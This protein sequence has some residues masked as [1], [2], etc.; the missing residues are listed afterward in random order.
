MPTAH[1]DCR[2]VKISDIPCKV[3]VLEDDDR[4]FCVD[5]GGTVVLLLEINEYSTSVK[6]DVT[7]E[8]VVFKEYIFG[9]CVR[10]VDRTHGG[11]VVEEQLSGILVIQ[12][13]EE[14]DGVIQYL[15]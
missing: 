5:R 7:I 9:I 14:H 8:A 3:I 1:V 13:V 12:V 6:A 15:L 4:C 11:V 2:S 10:D